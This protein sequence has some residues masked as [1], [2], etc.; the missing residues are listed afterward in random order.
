MRYIAAY[1]LLQIG[2]KASPSKSDIS[3]LLSTVGCET[4][5][6]RLDK[7]LSELDGKSIDQVCSSLSLV[8]LFSNYLHSSSPKDLPNFLL[9]LL[10]EEVEVE[11]LL[12][13]LEEEEALPPPLLRLSRRRRRNPRRNQTT[14]W[15]SVSSIRSAAFCHIVGVQ[16]DD[17]VPFHC[18]LETPII[19]EGYSNA[20]NK[21][22]VQ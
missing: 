21:C 14:I 3:K 15:V 13:H 5:D 16:I 6:E 7:L 11:V 12:Q 17:V 20:L 4:D 18:A 8:A 19:S 22:N 10:V 9:F 1:L 2:G